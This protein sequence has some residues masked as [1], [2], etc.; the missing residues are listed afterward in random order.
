MWSSVCFTHI[1]VLSCI[2]GEGDVADD[3]RVVE[4]VSNNEVSRHERLVGP[5]AGERGVQVQTPR[6]QGHMVRD[7]DIGLALDHNGA[8]NVLFFVRDAC[9]KMQIWDLK[10]FTIHFF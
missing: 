4:S 3:Q 10:K 5:E 1:K 8:G 9:C 2:R 6:H 7:D